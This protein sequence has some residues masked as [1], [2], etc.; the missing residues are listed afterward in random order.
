MT[1]PDPSAGLAEALSRV[2]ALDPAAAQAIRV[3]LSARRLADDLADAE[4]ILRDHAR[5]GRDAIARAAAVVLVEYDRRGGRTV[6]ESQLEATSS[7]MRGRPADALPVRNEK[8]DT[9]PD[10]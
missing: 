2:D 8:G 10:G 6:V 7:V 4:M 1:R 5:T 3:A 9:L